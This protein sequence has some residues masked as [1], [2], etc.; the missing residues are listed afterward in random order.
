MS[1]TFAP[2]R[3][4]PVLSVPFERHLLSCGATLLVSRRPGAPVCAIQAHVRGGPALDPAGKEGVA[5]LTGALAEQGTQRRTETQIAD[6]LEPAGGEISG[7]A[8]GLAG[9]IVNGEWELLADLVCDALSGATYPA[10]EVRR[11]KRR[12]LDRL[13][14]ERDD[15]RQQGGL[16]FRKLVYGSHWLGRAA[17]GSLASV[18]RIGAAD[19]R[20]H[21][22]ANWVGRRAILSVCG[23]VDP[24]RVK[25]VFERHL[26][27]WR[28]GTL[29]ATTPP[30]L[31]PI[32]PRVDHFHADRQQ[33]HLYLGHLGIRRG[34]PDYAALVVMDHVLGTGPGFTNRISRRLR[35]E[36]GLAYT[37]HAAIH[38]SAGILPG[39][40][41]AYIGTSPQNARTAIE[42][43]RAE[44]RRI[45]TEAPAAEELELVKGYLLG[46]FPLG[47][48]RASRRTSY[49][50]AAELHGFPPDHLTRLLAEF[51][52]VTPEDVRRVAARHL[53]PTASCI[54]A[55]GP[56]TRAVLAEMAGLSPKPR[57]ARRRPATT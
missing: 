8:S 2:P 53:H 48:E 4:I 47:F 1:T 50:V 29:L 16:R 21:R 33:V 6:L 22:Q 46:S 39:T 24:A 57:A 40:F 26:A 35:D 3:T 34:D 9:T 7:D 31:P 44:I 56:L 25:R 12:V 37:V 11:Q 55:S 10:E 52:A 49:L 28:P 30:E 27:R 43:F 20:A 45:Q 54:A 18:A 38:P 23:D 13:L 42:G 14:L 51:A 5:W 19:L 32:A 17:Y 15:P 36:L 41:T